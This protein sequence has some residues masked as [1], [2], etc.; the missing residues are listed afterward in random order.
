MEEPCPNC[1]TGLDKYVPIGS[2]VGS[3]VT[4]CEYCYGIGLKGGYYPPID[5]YMNYL[6]RQEIRADLLEPV[7]ISNYLFYMLNYPLLEKEDLVWVETLGKMF[8]V[9]QVQYYTYKGIPIKQL[10]NVS[11]IG[12][13][14]PVYKLS[15]QYTVVI[16]EQSTFTATDSS[17]I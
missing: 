3:E 5:V 13:G 17:S 14:H 4:D 2:D 7:R 15:R 16:T 12:Q 10:F 6:S 8:R 9:T 11:E 1:R